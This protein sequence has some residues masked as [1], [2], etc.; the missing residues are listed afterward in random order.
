MTEK[1]GQGSPM[2]PSEPTEESGIDLKEREAW[3]S[4][5]SVSAT[6]QK[7]DLSTG[8]YFDMYI[9][10]ATRRGELG[11]T[12][13]LGIHAF[14]ADDE[15]RPRGLVV[16]VYLDNVHSQMMIATATWVDG[17]PKIAQLTSA[18]IFEYR[19]E[20]ALNFE[21]V[22]VEASRVILRVELGREG[23]DEPQSPSTGGSASR[24][25][26]LN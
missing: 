13:D 8:R 20:D 10:D 4:L 1:I 25:G 22:A 19:P 18:E 15:G 12:R 14:L 26:Y 17:Q 24:A 9:G 3:T 23:E 2:P 7:E 11:F 6:Y 16:N 21:E 5:F